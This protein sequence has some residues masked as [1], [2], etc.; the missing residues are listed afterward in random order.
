M[1]TGIMEDWLKWLDRR[2]R[3]ARIRHTIPRQRT[4]TP[5]HHSHQHQTTVSTSK[6]NISD[7]THGPRNHTNNE[8]DVQ[9]TST[10]TRD[11]GAGKIDGDHRTANSE[12]GEHPASNLLG[13]QRMEG[14]NDGDDRQV[15]RQMWIPE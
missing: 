1:T 12:R 4:N 10:T 9:E 2:M 14:D 7:T 5:S 13:Y 11:D 8:A 3:H 6:H 15:F